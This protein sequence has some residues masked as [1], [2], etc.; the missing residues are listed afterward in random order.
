MSEYET[1][2]NAI[3]VIKANTRKNYSSE[4]EQMEDINAALA[5]LN[6]YADRTIYNYTQM[7]NNV[8]KFVAQ[9]LSTQKATKAVQGMANLAG[10]SGASAE[11]SRN[12]SNVASIRRN[13]SKN[14]LELVDVR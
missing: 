4:A 8:G 9:G 1:K 2:M 13:Y 3:Q 6:D 12:I 14:G 10:A 7:T 11:G 5:E